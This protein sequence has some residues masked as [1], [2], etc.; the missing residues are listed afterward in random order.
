MSAKRLICEEIL[1]DLHE[2]VDVESPFRLPRFGV[3]E[4][5]IPKCLNRLARR[6]HLGHKRLT[7]DKIEVLVEANVPSRN[8]LVH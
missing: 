1:Y 4:G 5:D 7:L 2:L 3:I 8:I 6:D